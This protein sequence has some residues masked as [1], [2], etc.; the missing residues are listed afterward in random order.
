[1]DAVS[2]GGTKNGALAAEAVVVLN[3]ATVPAVPFLRK[4]SMQ[5]ASKMRFISAQLAALLT[6]DLWLRNATHANEMAARLR[7]ALTEI[8]QVQ[9]TRAPQANAVFA[10]LPKTATEALQEQYRFYEW[11]PSTGEVR[12]MCSWDTCEADV[13]EFAAAIAAQLR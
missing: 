3:P 6:D 11:N 9:I 12:W 7:D 4:T 10:I 13:D 2:F 5:L 8:P 1:V